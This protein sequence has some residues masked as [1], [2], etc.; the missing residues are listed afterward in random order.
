MRMMQV[1]RP[2]GFRHW[3]ADILSWLFFPPL[4]STV[5]FVFLVFWYSNDFSQGLKWIVSVSPFLVFIPLIFF[6]ISYKAGWINDVDMTDRRERPV[7]LAVF[8]ISLAVAS[9]VLYLLH[10]PEKFFVYTFSGLIMM[11][12]ASLITL[13]WKISFHSAVTASVVTAITI[14]GGIQFWPLYLLLPLVGWARVTLGKHT[15]NQVIGGTIVAFV[16][17]VAVFYAF[18]FHFF[19]GVLEVR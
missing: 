2:V 14:L 15:V 7:F 8:V 19:Y 1:M 10:V 13:S 5:F 17:T 3:V 4:V 11:I 9:L 6:V 18:G 16:V 12:V